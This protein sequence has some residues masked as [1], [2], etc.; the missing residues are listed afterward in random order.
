MSLLEECDHLVIGLALRRLCRRIVIT[1]RLASIPILLLKEVCFCLFGS[2]KRY[3]LA[4]ARHIVF[5][6]QIQ[7]TICPDAAFSFNL[8]RLRCHGSSSC[9]KD[10]SHN[11]CANYNN[12][13][14]GHHQYKNIEPELNGIAVA[15]TNS[16]NASQ[17]NTSPK[18][19]ICNVKEKYAK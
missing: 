12:G 2:A 6:G 11:Q 5:P 9:F 1:P 14:S 10:S 3:H 18:A 8:V 17:E 16:V 7:S 4:N 13:Y 15:I 19:I